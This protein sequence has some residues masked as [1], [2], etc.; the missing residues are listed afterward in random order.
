MGLDP[1][2]QRRLQI[3]KE[4]IRDA[5]LQQAFQ[6]L[7][8]DTGSILETLRKNFRDAT[9]GKAD[10]TFYDWTL[11]FKNVARF[12]QS[13]KAEQLGKITLRPYDIL[14]HPGFL[15]IQNL[16]NKYK[17]FVLL[18]H[19]PG[20]TEDGKIPQATLRFAYDLPSKVIGG[21]DQ[22]SDHGTSNGVLK[23]D[24][25]LDESTNHKVFSP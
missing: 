3:E 14:Q 9:T 10:P 18:G 24:Y 25:S 11:S 15:S 21:E 16:M 17:I 22:V 6:S 19:D 20:K 1:R 4:N 2:Q 5:E 7:K 12:N 23:P 13:D 8:D